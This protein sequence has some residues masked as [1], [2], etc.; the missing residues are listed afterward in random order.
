VKVDMLIR[1]AA[2]KN[3]FIGLWMIFKRIESSL[4]F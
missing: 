1:W 4:L 2:R 3:P